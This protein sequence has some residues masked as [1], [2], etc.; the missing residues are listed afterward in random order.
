M[1]SSKRFT[2]I[3]IRFTDLHV[4]VSVT[5][6]PCFAILGCKYDK[7]LLPIP[8]LTLSDASRGI[9]LS[10]LTHFLLGI[11]FLGIFFRPIALAFLD[12]LPTFDPYVPFPYG[13]IL[14]LF[15]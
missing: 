9:D 8:R 13:M 15:S 3:R 5:N 11:F 4:C 14:F 10:R 12:G 6:R 1:P 2:G 7:F